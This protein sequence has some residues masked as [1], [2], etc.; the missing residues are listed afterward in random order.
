[1]L[2]SHPSIADAA[3]I[4]VLDAESGEEV[5]KAFVVQQP[6]AE[7]TAEEVMEFVADRGG[8][9]QEGAAGGVHRRHPEVGVGE[10]PA[11]GSTG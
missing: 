4:G 7:L 5:P 2:L 3:V 10:D 11:Q 1:M 6:G 9:V 8:A